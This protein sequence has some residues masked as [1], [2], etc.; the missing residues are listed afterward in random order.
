MTLIKCKECG[1][2]VS[3]KA[4]ACPNC[5]NPITIKPVELRFVEQYIIRYKCHVYDAES[6]KELWSGKQG[7]VAIIDT[8][9][10]AKTLTIEI[11]GGNGYGNIDVKP[12]DK[13]L[14]EGKLSGIKYR[15]ADEPDH[16]DGSSFSI[17]FGKFWK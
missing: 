3:D 11:G 15:H 17:G 7:D 1:K 2:K 8:D 4:E 5:G 9:N 14:I 13:L 16:T 6:G 12:G 10:E